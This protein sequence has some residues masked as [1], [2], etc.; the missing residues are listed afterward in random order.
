MAAELKVRWTANSIQ[1]LLLIKE[2]ISLD[3]PERAETWIG[4]LYTTGEN[5]AM[6]FERGRI[7]PEFSQENIRELLIEKYRLVY[8]FKPSSIEILTVFE[9]HRRLNKKVIKK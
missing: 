3:S 2:I 9:G 5:L 4:E 1:D 6:F 8:R 7:V